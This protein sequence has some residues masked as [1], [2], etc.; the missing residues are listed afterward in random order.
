MAKVQFNPLLAQI[1]GSIDGLTVRQTPHG[2]VM[3]PKADP[4]KRWSVAQKRHRER[5]REAGWFYRHEMRNSDRAAHYRARAL[6][7]GI[8]VSS[9]VMGGFIRYGE[10]FAAMET[11]T[12]LPH[13]EADGRDGGDAE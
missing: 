1:R 8:P 9:F 3:T 2:P 13:S 5:M 6:E 11:P 10:A 7:R 12:A 4:P